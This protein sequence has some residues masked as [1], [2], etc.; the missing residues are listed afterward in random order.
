M[1]TATN[2]SSLPTAGD[3]VTTETANHIRAGSV[4]LQAQCT[5]GVAYMEFH[6][7][8]TDD[9]VVRSIYGKG[10]AAYDRSAGFNISRNL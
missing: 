1:S 8:G 10:T 5:D 3:V 4:G 6:V 2:G 9:F 7:R